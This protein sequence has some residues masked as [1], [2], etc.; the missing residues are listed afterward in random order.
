MDE[1]DLRSTLR[2]LFE[3][4]QLGVLATEGQGQPYTSLVAFMATDD[5]KHLNFATSRATR[6]FANLT[7]NNRVAMLIDNRSNEPSDF[8][9]AAGVTAVGTVTEIDKGV[10]E[11]HIDRYRKRFP[12]LE[13][14]VASP[15]SALLQIEVKTYYVVT[16]FQHVLELHIDA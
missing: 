6:K 14:F 5:L 7:A 13:E 10:Y 16:R 1:K 8:R 15:T 11:E 9:D 12:H 3:T 2:Q 4:Q